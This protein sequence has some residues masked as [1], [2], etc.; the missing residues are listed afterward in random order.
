MNRR[1]LLKVVAGGASATLWSERSALGQSCAAKEGTVRDRLWLFGCPVNTDFPYV[2]KRSLMSP[3]EGAYYMGIPNLI[4]VNTGGDEV[5]YGH[6]EPPFDQYAIA[7]RPFR[8]VA[9]SIVGTTGATTTQERRLGIEVAKETPN[10]VALMMDDFFTDEKEGKLAALTLEELRELQGRLKGAGKK[11]DLF[12]TL[13]TT[14]LDEALG[15]YLK[16]ID[17]VTL[18]TW[19]PAELVNLEASLRKLERLAPQKRKML[20]CY[21]IDYN[22]KGPIPLASMKLQCRTGL[23]WLRQGRIE[24]LV[25]LGNT[26]EDLGY[27]AVEWTRNWIEQVGNGKV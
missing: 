10:F 5:K 4:M 21:W 13:Y 11:L 7:L 18:W 12:V 2:G 3:A 22:T 16:L 14:Q 24:G 20:G 15:E 27:E 23:R 9:W 17:V 8:R 25:F 6:F 26:N 19:K 1:D